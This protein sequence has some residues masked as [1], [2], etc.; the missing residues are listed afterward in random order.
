MTSPALPLSGKTVLV[1]RGKGQ[2]KSFSD[3]IESYGGNPVEIPLIAFKPVESTDEIQ[4]LIKRLHTYDWL[5]LTS[6][7][8]VETFFSFIKLTE[9]TRLPKIAVIG[10][11]TESCIKKLG[12]EVA[13]TPKEYVAEGF[14][15][16]FLPY[17]EPGM[18]VLIPKGNLARDYI[19]TSLS[20]N[21]AIVDEVVIYQTFFPEESKQLLKEMLANKS[22]NILTFTSPSTVDHFMD[23]VKEYNLHHSLEDCVIGCIGPITVERAKYYELKVH[24]A[25][26]V[27]TVHHMLK[28]IISYIENS[29]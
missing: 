8:A 29:H 10:K 25:P 14:V 23:V 1:P 17:I 2:A 7:V 19:C 26:E 4:M 18:K 11:K 12:L 24:S 13:F 3:L 16:E 6:N 20:A 9:E 5:I 28:S 27:Y 15:E 21:G 22:I